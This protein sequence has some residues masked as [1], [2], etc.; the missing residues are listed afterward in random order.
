MTTIGYYQQKNKEIIDE[1]V[2]TKNLAE[3]TQRVYTHAAAN[4]SYSQDM[5]MQDL[6][7]EADEEEDQRIRM[8]RRKIKK[9]MISYK[10]Y[11]IQEKKEPQTINIYLGKIKALYRF[12]EIETPTIPPITDT[13][14]ELIEDIPNKKHIR[15]ALETT[16]NLRVQA[17]ILFMSSSGTS[18]NETTSLTIQNFI[19]ATKDYHHESSIINVINSLETQEAV[20]PTFQLYRK[21]THYPYLTFCTPEA[22]QKIVQM[23]KSRIYKNPELSGEDAL[24]YRN[25][26]TI[27]KHFIRLNDKLGW[28]RKRNHAFFHPHA[29]RKFFATELLKSDMDSMTIDFLSGR[30]ISKTHQAYFKADPQKLKNKYTQFMDNLMIN[31]KLVYKDVTSNELQELEYYREKD[32]QRDKKLQELEKLLMEYV[33]LS[34]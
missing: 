11:L 27:S 7:D 14:H 28:G 33:H 10:E 16:N 17:L 4:Y 25:R 8:K 29:L 32:K 26:G 21:K 19:D 20:V 9:R 22:T 18:V 6:L 13:T 15:I 31:E 34:D 3:A 23:L 2:Q 24:F 1:I 5:T 12:F 30:T